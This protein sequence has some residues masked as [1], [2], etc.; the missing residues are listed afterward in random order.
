MNNFKSYTVRSLKD[1][2]GSP[3]VY[4]DI[5]SMAAAGFVPGKTYVRDVSN[6]KAKIV[7]TVQD[8]GTHVVSRKDEAGKV[9]PI[10][11]INS[12]DAF[13]A[14]DGMKAVR[15]IVQA[16]R[17]TILPLASETKRLARLDRLRANIAQG[18]VTTGSIAS[19]GCVMDHAAH[20]GLA[21]AGLKARLAMV[22]EF[23]DALLTHAA[24]A[25]DVVSAETLLLSGP[26][27]EVVQDNWAMERVGTFD[28]LAMGLPCSGASIAGKSKRKLDIMESHPEVGG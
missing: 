8:N 10:I 23:D 22:N 2:K 5:V 20:A 14:F 18:F 17:I 11:D 16:N 21:R 27:Q 26:M 6:G 9:L 4:L 3:R 24:N 19:G 13:R 7:L 12:R 1:H 28:I 15:I 25:N